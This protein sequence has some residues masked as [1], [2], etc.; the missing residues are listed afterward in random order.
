MYVTY[1]ERLKGIV[2]KSKISAVSFLPYR[3]MLLKHR[4]VILN[5]NDLLKERKNYLRN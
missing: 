3:K 4:V 2:N 5:L 1:L